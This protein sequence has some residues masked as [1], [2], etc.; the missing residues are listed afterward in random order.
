[1][2]FKLNGSCAAEFTPTNEKVCI[3][4]KETNYKP[5][6][7]GN[8]A[9]VEHVDDSFVQ[10]HYTCLIQE[11]FDN[12]YIKERNFFNSPC[13][14]NL[15]QRPSADSCGPDTIHTKRNGTINGVDNKRENLSNNL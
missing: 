14:N 1:M 13:I 8:Y 5:I 7:K 4:C 3:E 11:D 6:S 10:P 12:E 9:D 2:I 15:I